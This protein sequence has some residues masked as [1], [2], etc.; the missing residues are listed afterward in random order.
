MIVTGQ[1]AEWVIYDTGPIGRDKGEIRRVAISD[2]L[3]HPQARWR[4]L[5][6]NRNF[7]GVYRWNILRDGN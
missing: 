4:P 5:P 1:P 7:L 2:L 6:E 3:H